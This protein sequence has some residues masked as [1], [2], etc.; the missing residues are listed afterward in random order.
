MM[1]LALIISSLLHLT[2]L[3]Q[4]EFLFRQVQIE[5]HQTPVF[6]AVD[7]FE[8]NI[9]TRQLGSDSYAKNFRSYN[10]A[11]QE[12]NSK[13]A[14]IT[15]EQ[16]IKYGNR[17]PKYPREAIDNGWQGTVL[18]KLSLDSKGHVS[19]TDIIE[20]SG[21]YLLDMAAKEASLFWSFE[22]LSYSSTLVAP[23]RF[24]VG[25]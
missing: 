3:S 21:F 7:D 8:L 16:I 6:V 17:L 18:L 24:I 10:Q 2:V 22:G 9:R 14:E 20:S 23:I 11:I 25:S 12:G 19:K 5:K 13:F 1:W 4:R 15:A